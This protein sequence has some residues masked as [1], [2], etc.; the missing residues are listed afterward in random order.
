[1]TN[2][3]R[4]VANKIWE[5]A[6]I[7]PMHGN[8]IMDVIGEEAYIKIMMMQKD[9]DEY[10]RGFIEGSRYAIDNTRKPCPIKDISGFIDRLDNDDLNGHFRKEDY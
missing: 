4:E 10:L 1:M 6:R 9:N 2:I 7:S 3:E 5:I 8:A